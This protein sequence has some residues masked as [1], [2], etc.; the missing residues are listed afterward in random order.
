MLKIL[1]C[2]LLIFASTNSFSQVANAS[3]FSSMRSINPG[4]AHLRSV[5]FLDVAMSQTEINKFQDYTGGSILNGINTDIELNKSTIFYAGKGPGIT[6]EVL[7]DNENASRKEKF[8]TSSY[9]RVTETKGTSST[10]KGI[11]DIGFF[12]VELGTGKYKYDYLFEVDTPPNLN[13]ETQNTKLDY[14]LTKIGTAIEVKGVSIGGFYG[15]QKAKGDV[16]TTLFNPDNG[17][18]GSPETSDLEYETIFYGL[19][20]GYTSKTLHLELSL[21][22]ISKQTLDQT[23][24]YLLE[25]ETPKLGQRISAVAEVKFGKLSLGTRVRQIKGNYTDFEELISSNMLSVNSNES[26]SKLETKFNFS[27]GSGKGL[28]VSGFYSTSEVK[29]EQEIDWLDNGEKYDTT[30]TQKSYGASI[31]YTY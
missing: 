30:I 7:A 15:I 13:K 25:L 9:E 11:I 18:P 26:D 19:G 10:M 28:S 20:A 22:K 21:E 27:W 8:E 6:L 14:S 29:S 4:V 24:T 5:G 3:F 17:N 16:V 12:G 23:N 31:S 2:F 1:T